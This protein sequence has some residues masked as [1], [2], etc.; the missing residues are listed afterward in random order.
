MKTDILIKNYEKHLDE[1]C[2]EM[3]LFD[4][5]LEYGFLKLLKFAY[6]T[7]QFM[8]DEVDWFHVHARIPVPPEYAHEQKWIQV[9][10]DMDGVLESFCKVVD[11]FWTVVNSE[12]TENE[13]V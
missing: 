4:V 7:N 1:R 11:E 6:K 12:Y 8:V 5:H 10:F 9:T 3:E 13:D 2:D